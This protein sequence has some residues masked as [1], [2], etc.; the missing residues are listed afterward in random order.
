MANV[1]FSMDTP[2]TLDGPLERCGDSASGLDKPI[3]LRIQ[4]DLYDWSRR[5]YHS[6]S[7][8]TWMVEVQDVEEGRRLRQGLTDFLRCFGG[9]EWQQTELLGLV[10]ALAS[11]PAVGEGNE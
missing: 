4:P 6:W 7:G 10:A 5:N 8:L 1:S 9:A 11:P 2:P 3:K